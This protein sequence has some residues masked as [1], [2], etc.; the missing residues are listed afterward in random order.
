MATDKSSALHA[1]FTPIRVGQLSVRNR[2]LS[3]AHLTNFADGGMPTPRH[4]AY[5]EAKARG[6]I[7]M[8][9][10]EGSL[11]HPSS[12]TPE[13]K[14]IELWR[15]DVV[16]PLRETASAVQRSGAVLIA[17]LNHMGVGWAPSP[18]QRPTGLRAHEMTRAEISEV[19][20][21]F[22]SAALRVQRA[23]LDGI[24][25]H[26][27]HGYLIEQFLSPLTNRRT[28]EYGGSERARLKFALDVLR[29]VRNVVGPDFV[30]GM[31]AS[32]DQFTTGG[33]TLDDMKRII[34]AIAGAV[35][36][37]FI[38][39]SYYRNQDYG[40][41]SNS[42]VPMYVPEGRFVYLA[43]AVKS[44]VDLPVFCVNRIVDPRMAD[45]IIAEGRA[46]MVAMTRA[47]IADPLLA[48][49]AAEGRLDE[50][51]PCIGINEG[52]L[53]QVMSGSASPM[54]CAVNPS[55]GHEHEASIPIEASRRIVIIGGGIAGMEVARVA[56]ERGHSVRL[57]EA[58]ESL[59]GQLRVAAR[60]P[61]LHDMGRPVTY[62]ERQF[63]LLGVTVEL[64]RRIKAD[65]LCDLGADTIVVATGSRGA[66][67]REAG[68]RAEPTLPW[69][70]ARDA[71]D[72]GRP[73]LRVLVYTSDQTMEPLG[74]ADRLAEDGAT[75][76]LAAKAPSLGGMV[77]NQTRPFILDRLT[78]AGIELAVVTD[79]YVDGERTTL[80]RGDRGGEELDVAREF[81]LLV[82][83]GGA[84]A[85]DELF[86]CDIDALIDRRLVGDAF[87]PRK[88][89]AATQQAWRL[90]REL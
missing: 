2:I 70:S 14:F 64:G 59:G 46:D 33:L 35:Q 56:A 90:G 49:K 36:L 6:G 15:D 34:P 19:I 43:E 79:L 68:L 78:R 23:G 84:V 58:D 32:G 55:A 30:V 31:R 41:A 20:D 63:E 1:L 88:M 61:G 5:W 40:P 83:A 48:V 57:I 25:I 27:S 82:I 28:D 39:V 42:I 21:A 16:E 3:S 75:V 11:V 10:T 7:G 86:R 50:I 74:L 54:T 8:I 89:V 69:I 60:I 26:A 29:A 4:R 72:A 76:M 44:V 66:H 47:N 80:R 62:F 87:A 22:A 45:D 12:A 85:V 71:F 73:G 51:R 81:D 17:Q 13:T 9:I 53:G 77:E 65:E 37:D 24:E 67:W 18:W 38:N 52:C